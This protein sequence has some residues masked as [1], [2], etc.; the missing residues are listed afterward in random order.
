MADIS[1][2]KLPNGN[3]YN[4]KDSVAREA[5]SS[6]SK[7][8]G[9]TTTA[10]VDGSTTNPITIN[11]VEVTATRGNITIYGQSEFIWNG[12]SWDKFGDLDIDDLG[13]FAFADTGTVTVTPSG[14]NDASSVTFATSGKTANAIT[15][16]GTGTV[17]HQIGTQKHLSI[18]RSTN[19]A[20]SITATEAAITD[21]GTPTT[22]KFVT[23]YPGASSKLD[24]V[25]VPNVTGVGSLPSLTFT[26]SGTSGER[27][28]IAWSAGA[29]PSL[30]TAISCAKPTLSASGSGST[31]MTGLGTASK[32]DAI[33][34][35]GT[36]TTANVAKNISVSTQPVFSLSASPSTS[37]GAIKYVEEVTDS[38]TDTVSFGAHTTAEVIKSNI[39]AT[40]AARTFHGDSTAF[41]VNPVTE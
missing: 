8:I 17:P 24:S 23:S 40:A 12:D 33:T 13:D 39:T 28:D 10:L 20:V 2:I 26:L 38:G 36:P 9:K 6:F 34:G 5:M 25:S 14:H 27:L 29:L 31:V 3:V 15:G 7:Y 22:A 18:S 41:T 1:Q 30:G 35:L 21:L 37:T 16:I 19:A 4:I 32:G 11:G